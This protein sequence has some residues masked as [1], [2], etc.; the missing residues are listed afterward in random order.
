L[1]PPAANDKAMPT[2][3]CTKKGRERSI[4]IDHCR[5]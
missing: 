5:V 1:S 4:T 3:A 2:G